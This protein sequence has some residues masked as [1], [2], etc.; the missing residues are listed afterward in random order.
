M[1]IGLVFLFPMMRHPSGSK[2]ACGE[3]FEEVG[4]GREM[5]GSRGNAS[6]IRDGRRWTNGKGRGGV[7]SGAERSGGAELASLLWVGFLGLVE[8]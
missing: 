3:I 7:R 4:D 6:E 1:E 8:G 5:S 2:R